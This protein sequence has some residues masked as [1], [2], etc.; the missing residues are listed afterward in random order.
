MWDSAEVNKIV[1][2]AQWVMDRLELV[3]GSRS[4]RSLVICFGVRQKFELILRSVT[5]VKS[6]VG[7]Y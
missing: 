2:T 3:Q 6:C 5:V 7:F 1:K 4:M